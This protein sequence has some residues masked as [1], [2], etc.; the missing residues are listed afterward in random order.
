MANLQRV[1]VLTD[2][3][4]C[5]GE[6]GN[7]RYRVFRHSL[8]PNNKCLVLVYFDD[9]LLNKTAEEHGMK[10]KLQDKPQSLPF[11]E[12]GKNHF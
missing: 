5:L 12:A 4:D 3:L 7:L 9:S 8:D 6:D 2:Q 1:I 10:I 11:A